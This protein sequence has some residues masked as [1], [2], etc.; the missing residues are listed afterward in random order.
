MFLQDVPADTL[1]FM[2]LG[3]AVILGPVGVFRPRPRRAFPES[4]KGSGNTSEPGRRAAGLTPIF[5]TFQLRSW[6]P[7]TRGASSVFLGWCT[8]VLRGLLKIGKGRAVQS[9]R[10]EEAPSTGPGVTGG[11]F[12]TARSAVEFT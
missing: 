3:Y 4:A 2:I 8:G 1:S 12:L 10:G 6:M 9:S 5:W 11:G 7:Y